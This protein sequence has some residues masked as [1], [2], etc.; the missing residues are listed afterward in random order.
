[1]DQRDKELAV[2][3]V[4]SVLGE[5]LADRLYVATDCEGFVDGFDDELLRGLA[6]ECDQFKRRVETRERKAEKCL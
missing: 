1:M 3:Q 4:R 5:A 2:A 6:F